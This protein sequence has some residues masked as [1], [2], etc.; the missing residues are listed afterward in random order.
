[1]LEESFSP[2][3]V[4]RMRFEGGRLALAHPQR[5]R[6]ARA[7]ALVEKH[8]LGY[9]PAENAALSFARPNPLSIS[10]VTRDRHPAAAQAQLAAFERSAPFDGRAA[11]LLQFGQREGCIKAT[12]VHVHRKLGI[13]ARPAVTRA[14]QVAAANPGNF[15]MPR[16]NFR[17]N[18][19]RR[20]LAKPAST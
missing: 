4:F 17:N 16:K 10:F 9:V 3:M 18:P 7:R 1:M 19:S 6:L 20:S 13:Q 11:F 2:A 14:P 8:R 15:R 5:Q 12:E